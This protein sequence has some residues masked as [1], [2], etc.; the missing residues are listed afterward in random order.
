MILTLICAVLFQATGSVLSL[1]TVLSVLGLLGVGGGVSFALRYG[2]RLALVEK[3]SA[4]TKVSMA[5]HAKDNQERFEK[6]A[7]ELNTANTQVAL[8]AAM[9]KTIETSL[10]ELKADVKRWMETH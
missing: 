7:A 1:S 5:A 9:L 10:T 3:E 8:V 6:H 4:D 2:T